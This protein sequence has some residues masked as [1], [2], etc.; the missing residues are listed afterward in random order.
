MTTE[1][2]KRISHTLSFDNHKISLISTKPRLQKKYEAWNASRAF[3]QIMLQDHDLYSVP[4]PLQQFPYNLSLFQVLFDTNSHFR[5]QAI[6]FMINDSKK[7]CKRHLFKVL[8][9]LTT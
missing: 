9:T 7:K 2:S 4:I 3:I 6:H 5:M 8:D 1:T